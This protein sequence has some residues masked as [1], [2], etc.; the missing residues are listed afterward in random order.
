MAS[1]DFFGEPDRLST[2]PPARAGVLPR[3]GPGGAGRWGS[4]SIENS[5]HQYGADR[6]N[7][8]RVQVD[9]RGRV[10]TVDIDHHWRERVAVAG[11]AAAVFEAYAEALRK[12]YQLAARTAL[13]T[14]RPATSGRPTVIGQRSPVEDPAPREWARRTRATLDELGAELD[15]LAGRRPTAG[16]PERTVASPRG[17]LT[18]RLRGQQL[19]AVDGDPRRIGAAGPE[20]LRLDLLAAF[21]AAEL[22]TRT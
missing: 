21:R 15:H 5:G 18:L 16:T 4:T 13:R 6:S 19:T 7:A 8:V 12:T 9:A 20:Q 17:C 1:L 22:T 11:F 10:E 2:D 3:G 14:D